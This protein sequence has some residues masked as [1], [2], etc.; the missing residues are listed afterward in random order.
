[1]ST[2]QHPTPPEG[3][4]AFRGA[5]APPPHDDNQEPESRN[6]TIEEIRIFENAR[7]AVDTLKKTFET[8]MVIARGV[9]AAR[10]CADRIGGKQA[11]DKLLQQ[12]GIRAALGKSTASVKSTATNLLRILDNLPEV[13]SWRASLGTWEQVHWASP[14]A[15]LK[16]CPLFQRQA[17]RDG[18]EQEKQEKPLSPAQRI[19]ELEAANAHL[20]EELSATIARYESQ[21]PEPMWHE[22]D[23]DLDLRNDSAQDIAAAIIREK[24]DEEAAS[25]ARA[26]F[27]ALHH[28]E[29]AAAPAET[30]APEPVSAAP[31]LSQ[32]GERKARIR[33]A[34]PYDPEMINKIGTGEISLDDAERELG[35]A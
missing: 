22:P 24:G 31:K 13:E 16:Y 11:F 12:Q 14:T 10:E 26:I 17:E 19:K 1:V 35:L 33:K 21:P 4:N 8:W 7:Q 27:N 28:D 29:N 34:D 6:L 20:Q 25:I 2:I 30:L 9:K 15:V 5:H 32:S 18:E 23:L 3:W